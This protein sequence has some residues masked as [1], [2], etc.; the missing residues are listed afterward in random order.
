[1]GLARVS[2][3]FPRSPHRLQ[4]SDILWIRSPASVIRNPLGG[5]HFRD[6]SY[7]AD[8]NNTLGVFVVFKDLQR[9]NKVGSGQ[10]ITAHT[11]A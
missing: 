3:F 2:F 1:M 11:D 10:Y 7:L 5:I 6:T 4:G 8:E 9:V